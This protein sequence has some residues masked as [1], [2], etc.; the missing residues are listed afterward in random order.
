MTDKKPYVETDAERIQ[1]EQRMKRL[2]A[3]AAADAELAASLGKLQP[4]PAPAKGVPGVVEAQ[5]RAD[6]LPNPIP[7]EQPT[8]FRGEGITI[9]ALQEDVRIYTKEKGWDDDRTLGDLLLLV[10]REISEAYEEYRDWHEPNEVRVVHGKP[11][12]IPIELA[13]AV[14]RILSLCSKYDINLESAL[15]MK[16]EFNKT[17][18]HRHG[19]KRV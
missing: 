3:T 6:H 5:A 1:R 7:P 17:R 2:A 18:E 4:S 15:L 8:L 14:I 11:E 13:D 16:H 10:V 9:S 12:G 19:G